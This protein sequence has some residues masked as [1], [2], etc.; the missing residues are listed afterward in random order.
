MLLRLQASLLVA[1]TLAA[2]GGGGPQ[3][4]ADLQDRDDDLEA[5]YDRVTWIF[6]CPNAPI[7]VPTPGRNELV[8][9]DAGPHPYARE[10]MFSVPVSIKGKVCPAERLNRDAVFVVDISGSMS[11][12]DPLYIDPADP[13]RLTCG[14][15]QAYL[16]V[17]A[18]IPAATGN[19]AIVMFEASPR[20]SSTRMFASRA[21][22][23][24]DITANG[25]RRL[26]EDVL[27]Y[28]VGGTN[29]APALDRA[30]ALLQLSRQYATKE[31]YFLTDGSPGD[32][33]ASVATA[34]DIKTNGVLINGQSKPVTI[35]TVMLWT[36][37]SPPPTLLQDAIASR[38]TSGMPIHANA[39]SA[40]DLAR[41]LDGF[42]DNRLAG[43]EIRHGN[44]SAP[45]PAVIDLMPMLDPAT[46]EFQLPTRAI[47]IDLVSHEYQV[48]FNYWDTNRN[49]Y[50]VI[51]HLA[52]T[53]R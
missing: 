28:A 52:W 21:E 48:R 38:D 12:N 46:L 20:M 5:L 33:A 2:C 25:T 24:A 37:T 51:G 11:S 9:V 14:R 3:N 35:A 31:L 27:C 6:Q 49:S 15:H 22:L 13:S 4:A 8:L 43:S 42:T 16:S 47:D 50:E 30:R 19:Y 44:S 26:V 18:G 53:D 7:P 41:I 36:S 17:M 10:R 32:Q 39:S 45:S 1:L 40:A 23:E 34:A 29:Y